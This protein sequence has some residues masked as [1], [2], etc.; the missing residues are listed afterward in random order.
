MLCWFQGRALRIIPDGTGVL[1]AAYC[2]SSSVCAGI[3]NNMGLSFK[4]AK[5]SC[6]WECGAVPGCRQGGNRRRQ[7]QSGVLWSNSVSSAWKMQKQVGSCWGT[8]LH[9]DLHLLGDKEA[10]GLHRELFEAEGIIFVHRI[11]TLLEEGGGERGKFLRKHS[12]MVWFVVA[13]RKAWKNDWFWVFC[14]LPWRV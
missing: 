5:R 7:R 12:T 4:A 11:N 2:S 8:L 10:G 14:E 9:F 3:C 1:T 13:V 6:I